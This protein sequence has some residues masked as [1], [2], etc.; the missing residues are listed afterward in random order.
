[1]NEAIQKQ[2]DDARHGTLYFLGNMELLRDPHIDLGLVGNFVGSTTILGDLKDGLTT[3]VSST[4]TG[5]YVIDKIDEFKHKIRTVFA[6]FFDSITQGLV[7]RYGEVSAI[8]DWLGE[9]AT[10]AV[11]TLAGSLANVVPGWGYVQDAADL[12]D[13]TKKAITH[14]IDW[15]KQVYS[16]WGVELLKGEPATIAR[17]IAYHNAAAVGGGLKDIAITSVKIGLEAGGDATSGTGALIGALTGILQRIANLI[18]YAAQRM[19]FKRACDIAKHNFYQDDRLKNNHD[20]FIS[21]FKRACVCTPVIASL[22]ISSGFS[23]H[24]MKFLSLFNEK[25]DVISQNKYDSGVEYINQLKGLAKKHLLEY[26]DAYS[27][28]FASNDNVCAGVLRNLLGGNH[29]A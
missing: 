21:W 27:V 14:G 10:W 8:A 2:I 7:R 25:E 3:L 29:H 9:F 28:V 6:S 13:G 24:P 26:Q 22:T 16:G 1:M 15:A 23:G 19:L 20:E 18:E 11:S 5:K 4:D 17:A 12:Y